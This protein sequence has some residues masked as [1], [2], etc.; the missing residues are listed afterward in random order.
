[1][2][3]FI[4]LTTNDIRN[5]L[6]QK[7]TTGLFSNGVG[8]I[9]SFYT[10]SAQKAASGKYYF[11]VYQTASTDV[12]AE[13]QY[14]VAFGSFQDSGS[15][16]ADLANPAKA[17]YS[18]YANSILASGD[19]KFTVNGVD[20]DHV[21]II[22]LNRA[23]YKEKLNPG[24]WE[25]DFISGSAAAAPHAKLMLIDNSSTTGSLLNSE[26]GKAYS[27]VSG[28]IDASTGLQNI[29]SPTAPAYY[30]LVYPDVGIMILDAS[31]ISNY[32]NDNWIANTTA[33][34]WAAAETSSL[35]IQRFISSSNYFKA[36]SEETVKNTIYFVRA[37]NTDFN[38]S[39][40]P[41]FLNA[42]GTI[43]DSMINEPKTYI[44]TVGLYNAD[45]ELVAVAKLSQPL[46]KSFDTEQLIKIR[47]DF[48]WMLILLPTAYCLLH[49]I[50]T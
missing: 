6:Y 18:Q 49:T 20:K 10:S 47:L 28:S 37:R 2:S 15:V 50:F 21:F 39:T 8:V 32:F 22:N 29:Y 1:M 48:A 41:T 24:T 34:A 16:A 43:I 38:Y 25:Y 27:I 3:S 12:S 40:N 44:T 14:S 36:R 19:S 4:D 13:I 31:I 45:T 35:L 33:S 23:R 42:D 26:G 30:G 5:N 46:Q 17:V 7:V 9:Q 11:D